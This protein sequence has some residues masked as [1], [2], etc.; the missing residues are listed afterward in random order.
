VTGPL[1]S[2]WLGGFVFRLRH[3]MRAT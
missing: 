1:G 3:E 2:D